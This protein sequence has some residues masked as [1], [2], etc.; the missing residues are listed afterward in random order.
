[1][2]AFVQRPLAFALVS[3]AALLS[4]RVLAQ[5]GSPA[6]SASATTAA[7]SPE[8]VTV[9]GRKTMTQYRLEL[10]RAR[11][12]IF[13]IFN[14]AN[15]GDD[16]DI[17]CR[18]E[19]PT[20]SRVRHDVCRSNAEN[21]ASAE[22]G[23]SFLRALF[24]TSGGFQTFTRAG[25]PPPVAGDSQVNA[26]VGTAR[27][28]Q[29][30]ETGGA[31]ALQ[32]WE[33]E[34]RRLLSENRDLYIAVVKYAEL[35]NEYAQARGET[36][37]PLPDLVRGAPVE[38]SPQ[39]V[40]EASTLTEYQQRNGVAR[41]T[42]TVSI[43]NCE[44]GTTGGFTVVARVRNDAGDVTPIEFKETWQRADEQDHTFESEYPIGDNV[45]LQ[46]VRVRDLTCTC[47]APAP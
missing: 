20:G 34:W 41:V 39:S 18:A 45:F 13:R 27:A 2:R 7:E 40:C 37:A 32:Q 21:R 9:R 3:F 5:A 42:G 29:A 4:G 30:G 23:Q 16:T 28:Q 33:A 14:A 12:D 36:T 47:A 17:R 6:A 10:E 25:S 22:A 26:D 1:M 38:Q 43:S 44:A 31:T 35:E 46:S 15:D 11:D 8:E 19:Q 24:S